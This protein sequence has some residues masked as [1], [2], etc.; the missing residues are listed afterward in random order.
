MSNKLKKIIIYQNRNT[1]TPA[2]R[3]WVFARMDSHEIDTNLTNQLDEPP[4][5]LVADSDSD[6]AIPNVK[7]SSSANTNNSKENDNIQCKL[8][9]RPSIQLN[10]LIDLLIYH[11]FLLFVSFFFSTANRDHNVPDTNTQQYI[12]STIMIGE[13][14]ASTSN[15]SS[16]SRRKSNLSNQKKS[17]SSSSSSP[18]MSPSYNQNNKQYRTNIP[19]AVDLV[20]SKC[21]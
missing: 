8:I 13:E 18:I 19:R 11:V 15:Q 5:Q 10:W 9:A 1:E 20:E 17:G 14:I 4:E 6:A 12:R 16:S 2:I 21:S 7:L 3:H